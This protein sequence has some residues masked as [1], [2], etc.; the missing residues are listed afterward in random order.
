MVKELKC[1]GLRR[2]I[3]H[4]YEIKQDVSEEFW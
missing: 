4:Y 3:V 2:V 1:I